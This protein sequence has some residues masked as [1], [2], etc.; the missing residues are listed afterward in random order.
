MVFSSPSPLLFAYG[1]GILSLCSFQSSIPGEVSFHVWELKFA[2]TGLRT[3][4]CAG[5]VLWLM[6]KGYGHLPLRR[7]EPEPS[8]F[9]L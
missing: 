2:G 9:P 6:C 1:G 8:R 5:P 7:S 3:S 4:V